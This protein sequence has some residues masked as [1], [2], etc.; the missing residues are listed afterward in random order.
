MITA[1]YLFPVTTPAISL[2]PI[3]Y[4]KLIR[5]LRSISDQS[6]RPGPR[7][8]SVRCYPF[9][10]MPRGHLSIL[11]PATLSKLARDDPEHPRIRKHNA[12]C[13][14]IEYFH[15]DY[16]PRPEHRLTKETT[17]PL[18]AVLTQHYNKNYLTRGSDLKLTPREIWRWIFSR[19][20]SDRALNPPPVT[21]HQ[22]IYIQ[23]R[24]VTPNEL[25]LHTQRRRKG[26][27]KNPIGEDYNTIRTNTTIAQPNGGNL[28]YLAVNLHCRLH[29]SVD[30]DKVDNCDILLDYL[31]IPHGQIS[32]SSDIST[33]V[34]GVQSLNNVFV[35][36]ANST[37]VQHLDTTMLTCGLSRL[38]E[39]LTRHLLNGKI[40]D[41]S[42]IGG[43][44]VEG[45][46]SRNVRLTFG[47]G[48]VQSSPGSK[49]SKVIH[50]SYKGHRMPT[51]N[52]EQFTA[53]P[54]HLKPQL[55]K[56]FDAGQMFIDNNLPD[57]F[58]NNART[59]F[60]SKLLRDTIGFPNASFKFEYIDIVLSLNTILPKHIDSKNDH[61]KGYNHCTVYSFYQVID[62]LEY[63]VSVIMTTRL[64]VG[65]AFEK[66]IKKGRLL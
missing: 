41:T 29:G 28:F 43:A 55:V 20:Y 24:V 35:A 48:R 1:N 63:K 22:A 36:Y 65:A 40:T 21:S 38:H 6:N 18:L 61:R 15:L 30:M 32:P 25:H 42:R 7:R 27:C 17:P 64:T 34:D 58:P 31:Q 54:D 19:Q 5:R 13:L 66:V 10:V 39:N 60:A 62:E 4:Q 3:H 9:Y 50:W 47:F 23:E 45:E 56:I 2:F 11:S 33:N 8:I 14:V 16:H 46:A 59:R 26:L 12:A 57:S 52:C 51:I 53:V 37:I 49:P 44:V